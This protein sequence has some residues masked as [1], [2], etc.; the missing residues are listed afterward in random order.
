MKKA[1]LTVL[2]P[3]G[4]VA[5]GAL[6]YHYWDTGALPGMDP[7]FYPV[8]VQSIDYED[9]GVR[10]PG[11]AHFEIKLFQTLDD[12]TRWNVFPLMAPGDMTGREIKVIVRTQR[13]PPELVDYEAL[14]VE[15]LA[16]PP[17]G[18]IGSKIFDLLTEK[19][20]FFVEKVVLIEATSLHAATHL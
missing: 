9:R 11:T 6:A 3:F 7:P 5:A 19:G 10:I 18:R 14:E 13:E 2:V 4:V 20:Y 15:G 1:V 12:G 16:R 8:T 17:G